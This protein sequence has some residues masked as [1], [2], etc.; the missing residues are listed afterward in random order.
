MFSDV[1]VEYC[2]PRTYIVLIKTQQS[3]LYKNVFSKSNIESVDVSQEVGH[4]QVISLIPGI[5]DASTTTDTSD[6]Y[7][8]GGSKNTLTKSIPIK[9]KKHKGSEETLDRGRQVVV[10]VR[11]WWCGIDEVL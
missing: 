9:L 8:S 1:E 6:E 4:V 5:L 10:G 3:D 11:E 7:G 2:T